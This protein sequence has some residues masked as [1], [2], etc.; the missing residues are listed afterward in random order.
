MRFFDSWTPYLG[1]FLRAS[2]S[3]N[4]CIRHRALPEGV[5]E[6]TGA[7]VGG[8]GVGLGLRLPVLGTPPPSLDTSAASRW[9]RAPQGDLC[10]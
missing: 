10:F 5:E 7:G 8:L 2:S 1:L 4:K 3:N 9:D 6:C